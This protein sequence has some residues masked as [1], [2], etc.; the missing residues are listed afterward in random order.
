M[1]EEN[2]WARINYLPCMPLG[3]N[4]SRITG[5][6]RHIELSKQAAGEGTVL[7]KNENGCL[8]LGRGTSIAV[9]GKAQIDYIKGGGGS[10]M[11]HS[12]YTKNLYEAL[13]EAGGFD[14]YDK[15]S[16]YY[17]EYVQDMYK[18]GEKG[19]LFDEPGFPYELAAEA[20]KFTDTAII[21]INRYSG[22][23]W[24]R[25]ND[26]T[27]K[28]FDLSD[29]ESDMIDAV[30]AA[31]DKV[32]VLIN[33]GSMISMS[34]FA[35]DDKI[36]A[37]VMI[38]QGGMEGASAAAEVLTGDIVPS[39]KL[40]DTFAASLD[41][42]PS[43][44]GFHESDDYVKYI[45]DIFVGYRYFET[46]PGK[47]DRV[48][49]PFGYGLSYTS[50]EL[51]EISAV[52]IG[53]RIY[54]SATVKNTGEMCGKEVIQLY[55][56]VPAG[57]LTK[58]A[59]ELCAFKKTG[60][61]RPGER[62]TVTLQFK[63]DDMAS[64]DDTGVVCKSA[65]VV[66]K[67]EYKLY[68]GTSVRDVCELEYKHTEPETRVVCHLTQYCAPERLG[69]RLLADGS[70]SGVSCEKRE[71][72]SFPCRYKCLERIPEN[73][74]D[75]KKLIDV[76]NGEITLD[77]FL[78]QLTVDELMKLVASITSRGVANTGG[79]GGIEKYGIPAPMTADGPAGV[80]ILPRTGV[81]GTTAFPVAS[82]LACTWN[83]ELVEAVGR[84]GALE[85]KENNLSIWLTPALNIHRSPMCGRNFEYYSED[86]YISGKMAA[87]M[88]RGIQ[89]QGIVATPKH[90][91]C[92]NKET[93][94]AHSDS[95]VSERALREIYL[96]GFE[97]CVKEA[98]PKTVMTSYNILN[99]VY[100][101][102]NAEL[103]SGILRG[104]WGFEG[105][106]MTDWNNP[107]SHYRELCAGNDI[108]MPFFAVSDLKAAYDE[109][110]ITRDRIAESAKRTLELILSM[111]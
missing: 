35:W 48:I 77:E 8:P 86:P 41:D 102:E 65:Y 71:R 100:T 45:E 91:A 107:A 103:I 51:S 14:L 22:E 108:R 95:I 40:T 104:E 31:F 110:K 79:I 12:K 5:C 101:S 94:R 50:F 18:K 36:Q 88:V 28:Y 33:S 6:A 17:A 99:G 34:R 69:K 76:Y 70:Y 3:D 25:K 62:E 72:K 42:Y 78:T 58:A 24:D 13:K 74:E 75:I 23:G 60:M 89:S 61:L 63:T 19:G 85:M 57:K 106:V 81:A 105:T 44:A 87:A 38:W 53:D 54:V 93:R 73:E 15:L 29:K 82:M 68:L 32:I 10:G 30:T 109:G 64:Y 16:L 21:T 2:K 26:G 1:R 43:T 7:L 4:L 52:E 9:F 37:V 49:Y 67:G 96:R 80:R 83:T 97:I 59:K 56:G 55:Y 11:V 20:R 66:E 98:K 111:E 39:G 27:D 84:A 46:V 90:F 47:K 92:N